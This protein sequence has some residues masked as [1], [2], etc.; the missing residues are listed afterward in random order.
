[1]ARVGLG[2]GGLVEDVVGKESGGGVSWRIEYGGWKRKEI[3]IRANV[4]LGFLLRYVSDFQKRNA[5][6]VSQ[7]GS[8]S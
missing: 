5:E 3:E 8:F 2:N 6:P 4:Q 7:P 1:M